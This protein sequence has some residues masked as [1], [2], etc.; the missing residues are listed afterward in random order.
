MSTRGI[1]PKSSLDID[2]NSSWKALVIGGDD[3]GRGEGGGGGHREFQEVADYVIVGLGTAG[4]PLARYLSNGGANRVMVLEA[5]EDRSTDPK[6][7]QGAINDPNPYGFTGGSFFGDKTLGADPKYSFVRPTKPGAEDP[8]PQGTFSYSD[9][10]LAGGGSGHNGEVAVRSTPEVYDAWAAE[11][12]NPQWT[13]ANLLPLMKAMETYT[14]CPPHVADP[15]QRGSS[16]PLKITQDDTITGPPVPGNPLGPNPGWA[17]LAAA[18]E[19]GANAPYATDFNVPSAAVCTSEKQWFTDPV[20]GNRSWSQSAWLPPGVNAG[21]LRIVYKA[22]ATKVLIRPA[23]GDDGPVAEGVEYF[24][25]GEKDKVKRVRA[26]KKVILAAGTIAD[27]QLLQLSGVGDPAVLGP[28]GIPVIVAN[29]NVGANMQ[30][31]YGVT[32][33]IPMFPPGPHGPPFFVTDPIHFRTLGAYS[34]MSG[35]PLPTGQ[36]NDGVRR[37]QMEVLPVNAFIPA[38]ILTAL[39]IQDVPAVSILTFNYVPQSKGTVKLASTDPTVFPEVDQGFYTDVVAPTDLDRAVQ[40]YKMLFDISTNYTGQPPLYP[41]LFHYPAPFG[42]AP[43]DSLLRSDATHAFLVSAYHCCGTCR[44][45]ASPATGVVD[46][47]LDVFGVKGLSCCSDSAV[48]AITKGNTSYPA[49]LLGLVKARIEGA[50]VP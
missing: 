44:M 18:I 32:A 19:A 10:R 26:R 16:G 33:L 13:Y 23:R 48:P 29:P 39:G 9:G 3:E 47:N 37:L 36:A 1:E 6:V 17:A 14:P 38:S 28:L 20:T 43:D 8:G 21:S 2:M 30:N 27:A 50:S 41:P 22:S 40:M 4:A 49:F 15:T 31:H 46:G 12:G 45:S 35:T 25:N 11:T 5:G 24:V 7:L 34:D 42:P